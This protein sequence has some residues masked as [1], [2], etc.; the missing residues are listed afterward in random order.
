MTDN[1]VKETIDL[2]TQR[3][4]GNMR[5]EK[6]CPECGTRLELEEKIT[7]NPRFDSQTG[8]R[9][10]DWTHILSCPNDDWLNVLV[11]FDPVG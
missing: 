10:P 11:R 3:M 6:Y 2:V 9:K 4:I 7:E 1:E 8:E 5:L